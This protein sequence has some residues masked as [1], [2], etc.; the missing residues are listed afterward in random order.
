MKNFNG[1]CGPK[2]EWG[3]K[4]QGDGNIHVDGAKETLAYIPNSQ[5][6]SILLLLPSGTCSK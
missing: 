4:V 5:A 6:L 1:T 2:F 3:K